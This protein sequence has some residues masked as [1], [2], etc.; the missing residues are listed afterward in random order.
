MFS[1]YLFDFESKTLVTIIILVIHRYHPQYGAVEY[2]PAHVLNW[3]LQCAE[4]MDYLHTRKPKAII[5]R[6]LKPSKWVEF[7]SLIFLYSWTH[8]IRILKGSV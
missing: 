6:D 5:H 2:T 7:S 8:V 3:G 4:A 1:T